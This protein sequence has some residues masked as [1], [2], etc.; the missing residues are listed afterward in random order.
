MM[1]HP[2]RINGTLPIIHG[3]PLS[4]H[5]PLLNTG[6]IVARS[7]RFYSLGLRTTQLNP[8]FRDPVESELLLKLPL[9]HTL[10]SISRLNSNTQ[11]LVD[12]GVGHII[13]VSRRP[14]LPLLG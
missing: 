12:K 7:G 2:R 3:P 5:Q 13:G 1:I 14:A 10:I 8:L 11:R 9:V 6:I 4:A